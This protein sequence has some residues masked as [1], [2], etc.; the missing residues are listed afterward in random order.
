MQFVTYEELFQGPF[1]DLQVLDQPQVGI[2]FSQKQNKLKNGKNK[3]KFWF[4]IRD[5]D[6]QNAL[7]KPPAGRILTYGGPTLQGAHTHTH[8]CM[9]L[10]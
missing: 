7:I 4:G 8:A 1:V 10:T 2:H 5:Y 9:H 3:F 6:R